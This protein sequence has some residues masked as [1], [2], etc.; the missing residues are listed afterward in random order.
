MNPAS[1]RSEGQLRWQRLALF[2][3][4]ALAACSDATAGGEPPGGDGPRPNAVD[5]GNLGGG[6]ADGG[7]GSESSAEPPPPCDAK[8]TEALQAS[9]DAAHSSKTDAV[10]AVKTACGLRYFSSGPGKVEATALHRI[11]SVSKTYTG[12]VVMKLVDEGLVSLDEPASKWLAGIPGQ[13]TVLVRHLLQHTSGLAPFDTTLQ[14]KA[15]V[16]GKA[17]V[18]PEEMLGWSF[19]QGLKANP[20]TKVAYGNVNFVA[21]GVIAEKVTG[22][23]LAALIREK[24]L[25][26]VG[27]KATFF[28]GVETVIGA[29]AIGRNSGGG[30]VTNLVNPAVTWGCGSMVAT[31]G[32]T[33][34]WIEALGSGKA[35]GPKSYEAATRFEPLA[36]APEWK[37]GLGLI[38]IDPSETFGGGK[39]WG[40]VGDLDGYHTAAFYF[41]DKK[42]TVVSI[43]DFDPPNAKTVRDP[44]FASVKI[45]FAGGS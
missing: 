1:S 13:S 37:F 5:G 38:E 25:E 21:L 16:T 12:A 32:D 23:T 3:A 27:A 19:S 6:K 11:A 22:K 42:T 24:E 39:A 20:G 26:I 17:K 15:N 33:A 7:A 35:Y 4:L 44:F 8:E 30:D 40:H 18:K 28:N 10:L 41:P 36:D 9:L 14:F 31:P 2:C 29:M 43:L 45:L 34:A